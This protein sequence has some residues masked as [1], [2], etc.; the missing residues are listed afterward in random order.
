MGY[1]FPIRFLWI[2]LPYMYSFISNVC[3]A[4]PRLSDI[5]EA[6]ESQVSSRNVS[7]LSSSL[8]DFPADT[9]GS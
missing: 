1:E 9:A 3:L 2:S 7:K 5:P 4:I 6:S 8:T